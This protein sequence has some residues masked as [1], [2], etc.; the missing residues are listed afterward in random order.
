MQVEV[1]AP[2]KTIPGLSATGMGKEQLLEN[3]KRKG[4]AG[5]GYGQDWHAGVKDCINNFETV[6]Y[7]EK[8]RQCVMVMPN[9]MGNVRLS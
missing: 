4:S 9:Y 2:Q 6:P 5:R 3:E 7:D 8:T 1:S